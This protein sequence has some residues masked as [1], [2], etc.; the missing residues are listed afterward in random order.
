MRSLAIDIA[1][2]Y[3]DADCHNNAWTRFSAWRSSPEDLTMYAYLYI[4]IKKYMITMI[5][6]QHITHNMCAF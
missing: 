2:K 3:G 4:I 5:Y 6:K 1:C